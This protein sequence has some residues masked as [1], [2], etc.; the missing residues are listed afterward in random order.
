MGIGTQL[1][2]RFGSQRI[3]CIDIVFI[4][5]IFTQRR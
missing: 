3:N 1:E 2:N 5:L 4:L